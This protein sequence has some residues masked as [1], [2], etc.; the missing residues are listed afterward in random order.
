MHRTPLLDHITLQDE[1]KK[2]DNP[3]PVYADTLKRYDDVI[4]R[5]FTTGTPIQEVVQLRSQLVDEILLHIWQRHFPSTPDTVALIAV[6]GYG[7]SEMMPKS[8]VDLLILLHETDPEQHNEALEQF[9]TFLWDIGLDIG[10]SV[11]TVAECVEQAR[12]DITVATNI[13]ET[14][15]LCGSSALFEQMQTETAPDKIWPSKA[16]FQAKLEEQQK[17]HQRFQDSSYKLEPNIKE[18]LG[19]LRDIQMIGWVVKRHFGAS[20]LQELVTHH[21][22]NDDEYQLLMGGQALLWKIRYL[23]HHLSGRREDRLLFDRQRELAHAFGYLDDRNNL[24]IEQLMQRYYRTVLGL[25]RL[26]EML[27]QLFREHILHADEIANITPLTP[28]FQLNRGYLETVDEEVFKR[29]PSGLLELFVILSAHPEI[30]G[31]RANTIRQIRAHQYLIDAQFRADTN[32]QKLFLTLFREPQ[33]LTHQIRLMHR[34]RVLDAYL[35]AFEKISGR[36]QYDL[37]HIYTV[38]QHTLMVIRNLRR[39]NLAKHQDELPLCYELCQQVDKIELLFLAGLFHDIAKGRGGDHAQLGA[40]DAE[41]FCQQHQLKKVDVKLVKWLVKNHLIMSVTAQRKDISDPEVIHDFASQVSSVKYLTHLYLLTVADIRG[42]NPELWN[43]WK[44]NLL[45][46]LYY[47]TLSA[48]RRGLDNPLDRAEHIQAVQEEALELMQPQ[49]NQQ[50]ALQT[51]WRDFGDNYFLRHSAKEVVWHSSAI[52]AHHE[53]SPLITF[54]PQAQ[55]GS[56]EFFIYTHDSGNLFAQV[57][58]VMD[59]LNLN[60]VNA[61]IITADNGMTLDTFLLLEENGEAIT[62]TSRIEQIHRNL[63]NSISNNTLATPM[64]HSQSRKLKEFNVPLR[65]SYSNDLEHRFT[66]VSIS[67]SDQSG[68]LSKIGRSFADCQLQVH[69]ARISTIGERVDDTFFITN[70]HNQPVTDPHTLQ[71]LQGLLEQRLGGTHS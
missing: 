28:Y 51:L 11:R 15:L 65:I 64:R 16:F 56:T 59:N 7:R 1:L 25:Q 47:K 34:Y 17:R 18:S 55:Q 50:A 12:D 67:A 21:F 31:V 27:L 46:E 41:T 48:L 14:R 35:P 58:S 4:H 6:G 37:F 38:D 42:T 69:N 40:M 36:M 19:G 57:T 20:S 52:L 5:R 2:A 8:D 63:E 61:R 54:H 33:G 45:K 13:M 68:L 62:E 10:H 71:Q 39:F 22:L 49:Q 29:Y 23:L 3:A 66:S 44:D 53:T 24:A 43:S 9:L 60:I 32:N 26:N 70:Q 30:K